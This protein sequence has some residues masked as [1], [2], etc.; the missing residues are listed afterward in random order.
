MTGAAQ[1]LEGLQVVEVASFVAGPLA[2]LSLAQLGAEVIRID[3]IGGAA[4]QTRWPLAPS[5]RSLYWA[6]LNK[7]KRSVALNLRSPEGRE[8]ALALATAAGIVVTNT[9]PSSRDWISYQTSP[10]GVPTSSTPVCSECPTVARPWTTPST[11]PSVSRTS[12]ALAPNP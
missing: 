12:P 5:G 10:T 6:G 11:R 8:L 2:T 9:V 1:H 3:P 4:D 7:T